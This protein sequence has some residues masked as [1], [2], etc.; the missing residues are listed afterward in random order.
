MK[1]SFITLGPAFC[2]FKKGSSHREGNT[3][4]NLS[5]EKFWVSGIGDSAV[6]GSNY[7]N[8]MQI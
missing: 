8:L 5:F 7:Q 1:K 3:D 4:E 2:L 6:S